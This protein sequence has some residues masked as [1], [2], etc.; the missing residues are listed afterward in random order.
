MSLSFLRY[1]EIFQFGRQLEWTENEIGKDG[2]QRLWKG[3]SLSSWTQIWGLHD[4]VDS[5]FRP[6]SWQIAKK[7]EIQAHLLLKLSWASET[8]IDL[9]SLISE[10][11]ES[12]TSSADEKWILEQRERIRR[13]SWMDLTGLLLARTPL[14][15]FCSFILK[16]LMSLIDVDVDLIVSQIS[17]NLAEPYKPLMLDSSDKSS[18]IYLI[19]MVK[20]ALTWLHSVKFDN[21]TCIFLPSA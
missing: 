15:A 4:Q 5:C 9:L 18:N 7:G 1:F 6:S 12:W 10:S 21:L 3:E 8:S 2:T 17:T 13:K 19:I 11:A 14:K 16:K 20:W